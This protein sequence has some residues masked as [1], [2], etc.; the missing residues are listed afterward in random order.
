M[1]QEEKLNIS[2]NQKIRKKAKIKSKKN[3]SN[4]RTKA[5]TWIRG[6]YKKKTPII[7][8]ANIDDKY[9]PFT[10]GK[11]IINAFNDNSPKSDKDQTEK[12][13]PNLNL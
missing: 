3:E 11:G 4:F 9:F 10:S 12:E 13:N 2:K 6:P 7:I 1:L 5:K 8:K